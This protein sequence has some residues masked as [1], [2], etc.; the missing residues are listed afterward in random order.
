[1]LGD[2]IMRKQ[3]KLLCIKKCD[4]CGADVEIRRRDRLNTEHTFCSLKCCGEFRKQ[5][6]LNVECV[7][8]GKPIHRQPYQIKKSK[9]KLFCCSYECESKIKKIIYRGENNPNYGNSGINSPLHKSTSR[10]NSQG[11]R[12]IPLDETHPFAIDKF[13]IREHRYIAEKYLMTDEQS[14][15]INGKKYL[16]PIYDVHHKDF[17]RLNNSVENLQILTRSEH[18]KIHSKKIS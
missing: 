9:T 10:I 2:N 6:N 1:M 5:E 14:I 4:F 12:L 7:I 17:N 18:M 13:W 8:C 16:N 15:E 3:G 11:Y